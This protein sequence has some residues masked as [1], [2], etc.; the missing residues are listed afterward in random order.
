MYST[1]PSSKLPC[2]IKPAITP[3]PPPWPIK[4]YEA[5]K[6]NYYIPANHKVELDCFPP[7]KTIVKLLFI[8]NFQTWYITWQTSSGKMGF[9]MHI[10]PSCLA[11]RLI[12]T[13]RTKQFHLHGFGFEQLPSYYNNNNNND[14]SC[15]IW[16]INFING[17]LLQC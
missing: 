3:P 11:L 17:S 6:L 12:A 1:S 8:L 2:N 15:A 9:K 14:Y 5:L 4:Y 13:P 10:S 7:I 16:N